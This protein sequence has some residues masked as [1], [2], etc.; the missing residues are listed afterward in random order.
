[1]SEAN[2]YVRSH[3]ALQALA[4]E[5]HHVDVVGVAGDA[6]LRPFLAATF[7]YTPWWLRLLYGLRRGLARIMG[8]QHAGP[9]ARP[10]YTAQDVPFVPGEQF[11]FVS[12]VAA[13]ENA[14]WIATAG[15]KH[16]DGY[17]A[18]LRRPD[19]PRGPRMLLATLVRYKHWTGRLY[20]ALILPFHFLIVHAMARHAKEH[21]ATEA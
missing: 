20:F 14:Y 4:A 2:E 15:D 10:H 16:L 1:M 5:A 18:V 21:A 11:T 7:S 3:P 13:E 17:I 12:V 19:D 9:P 8:L 6:E